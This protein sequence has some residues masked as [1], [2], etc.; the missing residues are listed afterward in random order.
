MHSFSEVK[1]TFTVELLQVNSVNGVSPNMKINV[2]VSQLQPLYHDVGLL[3]IPNIP[4]KRD[5]RKFFL[6]ENVACKSTGFYLCR[7]NVGSKFTLNL[8]KICYLENASVTDLVGVNVWKSSIVERLPQNGDC[9]SLLVLETPQGYIL[10]GIHFAGNEQNGNAIAICLNQKMFPDEKDL[11]SVQGST[12]EFI[13]SESAPRELGDLHTKSIVRYLEDGCADVYGSFAGFQAKMRTTV[14]DTPMKPY[15]EKF[16]YSKKYTQ[17]VM[18]GWEPKRIAGAKMLLPVN[19]LDENIVQKVKE[20]YLQDILNSL[21]DDSLDTL[22]PYDLF[23]AING[24]PG[25]AFVDKLNRNTSAGAP[26]SKS[27]RNFMTKIPPQHGLNE[28]VEIHDEIKNRMKDMCEKYLNN[29][30][31]YPN[32]KAHFKDEPVSFEKAKLK[33]TRVFTGAPMDY[34]L[35]IRKYFLSATKL[36]QEN[37]FAFE[38][39]PGT[40]AQSIEWQDIYEYLTKFGQNQ[41]VAGDYGSYDKRMPPQVMLAAFDVLI[42]LCEL[43]NNYTEDDLTIMRGLAVDTCYPVIDYFGD[44][45]Q[46]YGSNPSGHPLT[47]IINSIVNSLY[48]RYVYYKLNEVKECTTFRENVNL[49]TYGDD[50]IMGVRRECNWFNHTSI[51]QALAELGIE[52]TMADKHT[53]SI[54][55]IHIKDASFLKRK[56]RLDKDVGAYVCPLEHDSIE[57]MLI[58]WTRSKSIVWQQQAIAVCAS[59]N[60]EY[61]FYGKEI[62]VEKQIL[63]KNMLKDLDIE[64]W[65]EDSTFP[66]WKELYDRFWGYSC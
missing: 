43:S 56:W 8:K 45:I 11:Y 34:T 28:P 57:K 29:E 64:N 40:I 55:Y 2:H 1:E 18:S 9:G 38:A 21:K 10:G 65:I 12:H 51:S 24:A 36:I 5:I 13:S 63:L 4:P 27:K 33:K 44:L 66:S 46:F 16:G 49:F 52:Y 61:F 37:R 22:M 35:L 14:E 48:M 6:K 47:V 32:F 30:R 58:T 50:N 53:K 39:G 19:T 15:L 59:A 62:Y 7:D 20:G 26:W 54:P 25:V 42:S 17:P 3:K 41:I 31:C 23:T 60:M